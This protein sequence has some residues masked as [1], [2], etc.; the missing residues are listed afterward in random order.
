[1]A[2]EHLATAVTQYV[3][4]HLY[5]CHPSGEGSR[6]SV[7]LTGVSGE[8]HQVGCHMIADALEANGWD[9][10]FLGTHCPEADILEQAR[11]EPCSILGI[12]TTLVAKAALLLTPTMRPRE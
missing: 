3:M 9:V 8:L 10:R 12:S 7:V 1:M 5:T 6:G 2:Q 4:A 11:R